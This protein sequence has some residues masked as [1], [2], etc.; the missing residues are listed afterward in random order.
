MINE[1]LITQKISQT[2]AYHFIPLKHLLSIFATCQTSLILEVWNLKPYH[3]K[4]WLGTFH[5]TEPSVLAQLLTGFCKL[6][7]RWIQFGLV[8]RCVRS[9]YYLYNY[10][11]LYVRHINLNIS[12]PNNTKI[13]C[14]F[15]YWQTFKIN[16]C[17]YCLYMY[18]HRLSFEWL[19]HVYSL[20]ESV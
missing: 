19:V 14:N 5:W 1:L 2:L 3:C 11:L 7:F 10:N 6:S 9:S 20:K 12:I 8:L 16:I 13:I 17:K 15:A 4:S 18:V